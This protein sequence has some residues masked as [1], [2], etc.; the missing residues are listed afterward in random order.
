VC[1]R[2]EDAA[3]ENSENVNFE[4]EQ[5]DADAGT[6][7]TAEP[8]FFESE[9]KSHDESEGAWA[10]PEYSDRIATTNAAQDLTEDEA[11]AEIDA[12]EADADAEAAEEET[13]AQEESEDEVA[14]AVLLQIGTP[15]ALLFARTPPAGIPVCLFVR[16]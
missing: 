4:Q 3:E 1:V 7:D 15:R 5:D 8:V 10:T 13:E 12:A 9:A 2:A 6:A 16:V 14:D 11:N